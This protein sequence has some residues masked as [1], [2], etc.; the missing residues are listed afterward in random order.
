MTPA[1]PFTI[2]FVTSN[3]NFLFFFY[4]SY[5]MKAQQVTSYADENT[6]KEWKSMADIKVATV[7]MQ[8]EFD[9][10]ANLNKYLTFIEQAALQHVDL[11]VF[12]EQSL[13]GYLKNLFSLDMKNVQHQHDQA[14][15]VE[16]GT[17]VR[18]LIEAASRYNMHIIF[19]MTERD[20]ERPD[21]LYNSAVLLGPSGHIGTYRKVHQPGDEVHVYYPGDSFPVFE[22]SLGKIGL[23]IC[24][25]KMFPESTRELALKG[26]EILVMPTAWP[27]SEVGADPTLDPMGQYYDLLDSVRAFEN[28]CWFISSDMCGIHGDHDFYGHSRIVSP[29]GETL[30][31]CGYEEGMTIAEIDVK[32]GIVSARSCDLLGLNLLKDRRPEKYAVIQEGATRKRTKKPVPQTIQL[33]HQ[34]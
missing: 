32:K 17:S 14:E 10:Q 11:I 33:E 24:Y 1:I 30:A 6:M 5:K 3:D 13:Q 9:K 29:I 34:V 18:T 27:L 20:D 12:P 23:L 25:D 8:V 21:I 2:L 4:R 31:E 16:N 19:G 26:A 28:Q 22:T 7:S 15:T